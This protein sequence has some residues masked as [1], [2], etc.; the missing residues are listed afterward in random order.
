MSSKLKVE[1]SKTIW[2]LGNVKDEIKKKN[3]YNPSQTWNW[4]CVWI[5]DLFSC[6]WKTQDGIA[7]SDIRA[8]I[9]TVRLSNY[10]IFSACGNLSRHFASLHE[11]KK[12]FKCS[13]QFVMV[14]LI[15]RKNWDILSWYCMKE[16]HSNVLTVILNFH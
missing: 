7:E 14:I 1:C 8:K 3:I 12:P 10:A 4:S 9:E 11:G 5:M 13:V 6:D 15:G 2:I 16:S